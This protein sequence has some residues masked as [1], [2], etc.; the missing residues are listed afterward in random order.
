MF[1]G[2]QFDRIRHTLTSGLFFSKNAWDVWPGGPFIV[3]RRLNHSFSYPPA[4]LLHVSEAVVV[5][6]LVVGSLRI[7]LLRCV[8]LVLLGVPWPTRAVPFDRGTS[9]DVRAAGAKAPPGQQSGD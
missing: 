2:E 4:L 5:W 3:Q 1:G 9:I 6:V 8:L 7:F